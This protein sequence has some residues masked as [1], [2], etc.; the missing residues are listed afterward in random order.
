MATMANNILFSIDSMLQMK[1]GTNVA[2]VL[3][4]I[5][6]GYDSCPYQIL[7]NDTGGGLDVKLPGEAA[8]TPVKSGLMYFFR[9]NGAD[10]LQLKKEGGASLGGAIATGKIAIVV[11]A[12]G[13]WHLLFQD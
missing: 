3:A 7:S 8:T 9:N 4:H 1:G 6:M 11:S 12:A 2:D 5:T 13:A 10:P